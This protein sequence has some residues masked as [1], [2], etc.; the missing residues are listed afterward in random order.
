VALVSS[1][2]R[3]R[4]ASEIT[5][6]SKAAITRSDAS[7]FGK[8]N[9]ALPIHRAL[10]LTDARAA[11]EPAAHA[12]VEGRCEGMLSHLGAGDW[13]GTG[14]LE[15]GAHS[16]HEISHEVAEVLASRSAHRPPH[17]ARISRRVG[18]QASA[19]QAAT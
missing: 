13:S 6:V 7:C 17:G 11:V 10:Q 8:K 5:S 9:G 18:A 16:R 4:P 3:H 12:R 14:E 1:T 2:N 19:A 15:R